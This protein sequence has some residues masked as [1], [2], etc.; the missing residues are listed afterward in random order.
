MTDPLD[1]LAFTHLLAS[2]V[3]EMRRA[4]GLSAGALAREVGTDRRI[5]YRWEDGVQTPSAWN[6]VRISRAVRVDPSTLLGETQWRRP[7]TPDVL[8]ALATEIETRAMREGARL[9]A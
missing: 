4:A 5:V 8:R 6:V 9:I 3:G 1:Q 2:N 7:S